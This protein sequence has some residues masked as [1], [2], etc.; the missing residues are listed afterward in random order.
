MDRKESMM[1]YC[2]EAAASV[3]CAG[4]TG[5]VVMIP[6]LA[7]RFAEILRDEICKAQ[8][9]GRF[10]REFEESGSNETEEV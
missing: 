10:A 3:W 6:E 8:D 1:T 4:S 9:N 5:H 7:E 2:R